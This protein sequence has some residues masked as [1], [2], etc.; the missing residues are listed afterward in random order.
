MNFNGLMIDCCRIL[1][2]KDYYYRLLD[3]MS[4]WEMPHL[5]LHFTD[6][7]GCA[8]DIPGYSHLAMKNAF[9]ADEISALCAYAAERGISVIP[10]LESFGH[11]Q[12]LTDSPRYRHLY[13]PAD[14]DIPGGQKRGCL[15]PLTAGSRKVMRDLIAETAKMFPG[16]YFHIGCDEVD[17]SGLDNSKNII[18]EKIWADYV[19]V[20]IGYVRDCGKTPVIWGDQLKKKP[21]TVDFLRKDVVIMEWD[22]EADGSQSAVNALA[23]YGF[24]DIILSPAVMFCRYRIFPTITAFKNVNRMV[25][26]ASVKEVSGIMNTCWCPH[27]YITNSLYYAIAYC[28]YMVKC[29]GNVRIKEFRDKFSRYMFG[30]NCGFS[31]NR[32]LAIW[33]KLNISGDLAKKLIDESGDVTESDVMTLK[34]INEYGEKALKYAHGFEPA[35]NHDVWSAMVLSARTAWLCSESYFSGI[36]GG[37]RRERFRQKLKDVLAD[38][39]YEWDKT[40]DS[41][42]EHKY[43]PHFKEPVSSYLIPFLMNLS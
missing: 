35:K 29:D 21:S 39:E 22:Y 19:N 5:Q 12:Y 42:D 34:Y 20:I 13:L 14:T 16:N 40:R 2:K 26:Y 41:G 17:L 1:E 7:H 27:R 18:A 25:K 3:F 23:G 15:N 33:P 37:L 10:E 24:E 43:S 38:I 11:T 36:E 32:F 6:N 30:K 9:S 31:L 4:D 28:A 8:V